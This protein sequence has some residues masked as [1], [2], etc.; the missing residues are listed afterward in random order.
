MYLICKHLTF[1]NYF[2]PVFFSP[3]KFSFTV[4]LHIDKISNIISA[5]RPPKNT[6]A[7]YL[8]VHKITSIVIN[9]ITFMPLFKTFAVYHT[10]FKYTSNCHLVYSHYTLSLHFIFKP[11]SLIF[12][13]RSFVNTFTVKLSIKKSSFV[14]T[15]I[16]KCFLTLPIR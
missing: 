14:C 1:V 11:H 4:H 9:I 12:L 16:R 5:I 7:L 8:T 10:F 3:R 2:S 15:G 6:K 13:I